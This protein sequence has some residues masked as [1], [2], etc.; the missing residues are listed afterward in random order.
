MH[1]LIQLPYP[2]NSL[3]PYI[4][5]LT[6]QTH[7]SKHHAGYV[8]KL[9]GLLEGN[10]ELL[11]MDIADL[12]VNLSK[13][14]ES[15]RQAVFNNGGQVY[16]HNIYWQ[17]M[18]PDGGGEPTGK[19]QQAIQDQ[20]GSYSQLKAE[21]ITAGSTQF[22]SGWAWLSLDQNKQLVVSKTS[23]ADSPLMYSQFP[24]MVIDV[25][26]HAYYL[27]YKNL[28]PDYLEAFFGVVDWQ[29]IGNRY[30]QVLNQV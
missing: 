16:N 7:Y 13:V 4:D 21:L 15:V 18:S 17:S 12:L 2:T 24:L 3:E 14:D 23:N 26:E 6:V 8:N 25:W 28:R 5:E 1:A 22:G 11:N 29:G 27:K 20:F 10:E 30:E 9:N 19:L